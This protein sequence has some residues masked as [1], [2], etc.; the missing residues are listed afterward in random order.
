M[1]Q[2]LSQSDWDRIRQFANTPTYDREP[3]MLAP[4]GEGDARGAE[5]R[6]PD[7]DLDGP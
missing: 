3:E 4:E 5:T 6:P 1:V 2:R 7:G